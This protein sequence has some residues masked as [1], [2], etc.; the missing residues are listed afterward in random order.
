MP[1][2]TERNTINQ[3]AWR[4]RQKVKINTFLDQLMEDVDIY[5][6]VKEDGK[7]YITLDMG[8]DTR[9]ALD[10]ILA[11]KGSTFEKWFKEGVAAT[12]KDAAK[13]RALKK[14]Y[15]AK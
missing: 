14:N 8:E 4:E 2:S 9:A 6:E 1:R 7:R 13:L 3:Q 5:E 12:L 11:L 15:K 10:A